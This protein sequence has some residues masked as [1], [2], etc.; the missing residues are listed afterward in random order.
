MIAL[1]F[2]IGLLVG[3]LLTMGCTYMA[4]YQPFGSEE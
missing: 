1:A 4:L 2:G 3:M